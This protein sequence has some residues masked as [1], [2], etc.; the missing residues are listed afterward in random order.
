MVCLEYICQKTKTL[1]LRA[2]LLMEGDNRHGKY[3]L[4][5]KCFVGKNRADRSGAGGRV[6]QVQQGR[7]Y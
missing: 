7:P 1:I 4:G 6:I 5:K 2:H 3:I